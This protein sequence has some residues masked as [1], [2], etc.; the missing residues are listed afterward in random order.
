MVRKGEQCD[1]WIG[2]GRRCNLSRRWR[3]Q[4]YCQQSCSEIGLGYEGDDCCGDD[5]ENEDDDDV[6]IEC[7]DDETPW[8]RKKGRD[9][10]GS[11]SEWLL[12]RRCNRSRFWVKNNYCQESCYAEGRGYE[13]DICCGVEVGAID[14][15]AVCS[16]SGSGCSDSSEC[17]SGMCMGDKRCA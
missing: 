5:D 15:P 13:G 3:R 10:S 1:S 16:D 6:C 9:C 7:S 11:S 12:Q 2:L 14:L 8:M 17:C 4:K